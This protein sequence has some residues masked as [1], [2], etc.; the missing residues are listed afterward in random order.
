MTDNTF[1]LHWA[2]C[3]CLVYVSVCSWACV[4]FCLISV[5]YVFGYVM[6]IF[7]FGMLKIV[8]CGHLFRYIRARYVQFI[9]CTEVLMFSSQSHIYK[10]REQNDDFFCFF[11][12]VLFIAQRLTHIRTV[13]MGWLPS[14]ALFHLCNLMVYININLTITSVILLNFYLFIESTSLML[15]ANFG[16]PNC[17]VTILLWQHKETISLVFISI[18][19]ISVLRLLLCSFLSTFFSNKK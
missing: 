1:L 13:R 17:I 18:H 11:D 4:Y 5:L 12:F 15:R 3:C 8:S 10:L 7:M 19:L 9:F 16:K 6:L 14:I 2:S